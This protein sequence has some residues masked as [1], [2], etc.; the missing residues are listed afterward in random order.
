MLV[1][2][3]DTTR[4]AANQPADESGEVVSTDTS[5]PITEKPAVETFESPITLD[6]TVSGFYVIWGI[7]YIFEKGE[8]RQDL[9]LVRREWPTPPTAGVYPPQSN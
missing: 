5:N 9:K 3:R 1:I 6:K 8:F 2:K 4:K 7:D